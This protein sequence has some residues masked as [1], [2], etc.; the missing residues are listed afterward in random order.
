MAADSARS[1]MKRPLVRPFWRSR[2][3]AVLLAVLGLASCGPGREVLPPGS[4]GADQFLYERGMAAS[5]TRKWV[6]ATDYFTKLIDGYPQSPYR[7][8]AK[9]AIGDVY[10]AQSTAE[11]LVLAQNEY[12]EF[13]TFYPT[14]PR[15]DYAQHQLGMTYFKAMRSPGRDQTATKQAVNEFEFFLQ[16]YPNSSMI[17]QARARLRE[18][19][20]RLDESDF[21]IGLHYYRTRWYPGAIARFKELLKSDPGFTNRDAVYFYLAESLLRTE[22]KA[23]AL[24]YYE[25]LVAEFQSS[26]YLDDARRRISE[27]KGPDNKQS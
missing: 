20:D 11:S 8:D 3:V 7:A 6:D 26:D 2:P 27:L 25:R 15:A 9:L 18:S 19:K 4:A 22:N 21:G 1:G 16:R 17:P 23:E 13:L 5:K 24:P 14:S 12:R 10:L